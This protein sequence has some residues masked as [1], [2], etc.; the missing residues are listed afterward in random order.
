MQL[1]DYCEGQWETGND[2]FKGGEYNTSSCLCRDNDIYS[3]NYLKIFF[4]DVQLN[5]ISQ[6]PLQLGD[7]ILASDIGKKKNTSLEEEMATHSSI[8]AWEIPWTEEPGGLQS[9]GSQRVRHYWATKHSTEAGH[10]RDEGEAAGP[11]WPFQSTFSWGGG[12]VAWW[13]RAW[14]G[15]SPSDFQSFLYSVTLGPVAYPTMPQFLCL[16]SG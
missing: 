2:N 1:K 11:K 10:I 8:L 5:Y 13:L 7:W 14:S 9:L 15:A 6:P 12:R 4:W 3:L 16:L